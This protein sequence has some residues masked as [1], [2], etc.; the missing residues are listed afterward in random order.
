MTRARK[1]L[2][3]LPWRSARQIHA[4]VD[5]ELQF[6]LDMR[7]DELIALGLS[8]DAARARAIREF[9]DMDDARRYIG[10]VDRDIEA[11]QRRSDFMN[12]LWTDIGYSL[13]KFRAAPLFTLAA[14]ATLALGIGANTAIFSVVNGVLLKPLPFPQSDHLVRIRYTQQG[15]SDVST[16]MDL[17]DNQTRARDFV[18]F[19]IIEGTTANLVRDDNDPERVQGVRVGT[20]LFSLLRARPVAGR[21]FNE[22]DDRAGG[23]NIAVIGEALWKRDFGGAQSAIGKTVRINSVPFTIIGVA[24]ADQHFPITAELWMPK[25]WEPNE[26]SDQ[27]RG[28]RWLGLLGRVKDGVDLAAADNEVEKISEAMEKQFPEDF[29]ERRAHVVTLQ[30]WLVGDMRKPLYIMLGAVALVLL[31]ACANV[32]NLLLVRAT[33]REGE[34]AVRT[35]LGAG[36]GRL[37]RQLMTES[38]ILSVVGAAAGLV[39]AKLGM[40]LMLSRAPQSLTLVGGVS[41]DG[42]TLAVTAVV[43]LITGLIFGVLPAMQVGKDDLATALRAGGRGTRTRAGA[44]RT[45]QLIV[46]A[47]VALAVMLLTGAGLVLHSF[48]NLLAVDP[49]FRPEGVL[50]MKVALPERTYDSTA[51]RN[52]VRSLEE[53]A[54]ALPG[55]KSVGLANSV[56]LDGSGYNFSFTIRGRPVARP[57]DEPVAEV[58][59][60]TPDFFTTMG[61]PVIRGRD[62]TASDAPGAPKVLVVNKAFADQFFPNENVVGQA[63]RLGWGREVKGAM[64]DIVGVVGNVR[65]SGLDES[66]LPTVYASLAQYPGQGL[67]IVVRTDAAPASL[68]APIRAIVRELDHGVPVY[69]VMT[70][71]DRIASSV[72]SRRFY[73]TLITI[74]ASVALVLSAVGLYGVIAYAVSQRTHELGVRVALGA[75]GSRISRMVIGEAMGL[76]AIGVI[77][78]IVASVGAGR[79]VGT[80]LFGVGA[81]DPLTVVSVVVVLGA[82]AA[83]ASWLPARRAAR[84]DPLV[85]MRGD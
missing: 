56:P 21:F 27:T 35:A 17:V 6:H 11:A 3:R 83:V 68:A 60:V 70:M 71:E 14:I 82:V 23:A 77:L 12:D 18:G 42:T 40:Q 53:R 85:A 7:V 66:P 49:G 19:S 69:S 63:I 54:R 61:M 44:N 10:A 72:A 55:V 59:M 84:I 47:E 22:G 43:A 76:T 29:R 52:F 64:T 30:E 51:T 8:P 25:V 9:G 65:G 32:A 37:I 20:N 81:L 24:P 46:V 26:L 41:I 31:V 58:R 45:K 39:V 78:G 79:L 5:D 16:P 57:S 28:A 74:F 15:H 1:R 4:D 48:A 80:L 62:I 75:T 13:R 36:R 38:V 73:A 2:F 34:M 67:S 33:A 50:S